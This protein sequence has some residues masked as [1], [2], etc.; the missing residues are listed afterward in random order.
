MM[1]NCREVEP[2][3]E[4]AMDTLESDDRAAVLLRY[5]ENKR[6]ARWVRLSVNLKMPHKNG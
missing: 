4:E 6:F 1:K 2:L 3:L 5:F